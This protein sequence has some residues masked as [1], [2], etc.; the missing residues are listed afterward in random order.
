M[1]PSLP[2]PPPMHP[3]TAGAIVVLSTALLGLRTGWQ[4]GR[5]GGSV[6]SWLL[7]LDS[8]RS[9]AGAVDFL[10]HHLRHPHLR[11]HSQVRTRLM[12]SSQS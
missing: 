4:R 7:S 1:L 8:L 9:G 2:P 5:D 11:H 12:G 10:W 6:L 3:V